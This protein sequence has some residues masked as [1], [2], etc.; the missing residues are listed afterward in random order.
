MKRGQ[1]TFTSEMVI[2]VIVILAIAGF[3]MIVINPGLREMIFGGL[4]GILS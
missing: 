2:V 4:G 1:W 3:L